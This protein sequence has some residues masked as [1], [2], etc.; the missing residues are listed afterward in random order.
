MLSKNQQKLLNYCYNLLAKRR[1]SIHEI[2]RKLTEYNHK[3]EDIC[4]EE[5]LKEI[6][7]GLVK[8]NLLND[9]DYA[10]LYIDSQLRRKPTGTI[11][12]KMQLR[13][14]GIDENVISKAINLAALDEKVLA[15]EL[16]EKKTKTY[17][18]K[19]I[20]DHKT[21]ARLIRLLASNGFNSG[22]A[23]K[24]L[25]EYILRCD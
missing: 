21:Q 9:E 17:P 25:K 8:A 1:Y 3:K 18:L 12:I 14:K 5:E 11:K 4:S 16:L 7:E 15:M 6:L 10:N 2:T 22:L 23:Y 13:R 24:A 19:E 20:K